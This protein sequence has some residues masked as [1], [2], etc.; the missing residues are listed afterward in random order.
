[1]KEGRKTEKWKSEV[2]EVS[3]LIGW[4]AGISDGE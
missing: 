4:L 2:Q 3:A 1:M